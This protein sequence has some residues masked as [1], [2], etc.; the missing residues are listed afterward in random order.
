MTRDASS[1]QLKVTLLKKKD[2]K[3]NHPFDD[4]DNVLPKRLRTNHSNHVNV[5]DKDHMSKDKD[6]HVYRTNQDTHHSIHKHD[7]TYDSRNNY[8]NHANYAIDANCTTQI[9]N[10][11]HT[12]SVIDINKPTLST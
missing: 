2:Y 5:Y 8:R 1:S 11:H 12:N 10:V 3:E 9:N 6:N 4:L 7:D